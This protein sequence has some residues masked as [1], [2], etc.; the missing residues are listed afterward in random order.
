MRM[1]KST[2]DASIDISNIWISHTQYQ[3]INQI[4]I[5]FF[6]FFFLS[7]FFVYFK[8]NLDDITLNQI[9][10]IIIRKLILPRKKKVDSSFNQFAEANEYSSGLF[11]LET[12]VYRGRRPKKENGKIIRYDIS[13]S[14][15]SKNYCTGKKQ[16]PLM[17]LFFL[18]DQFMLE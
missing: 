8:S 14:G 13:K 5:V 3:I 9:I 12:K 10:I 16:R 7:F 6:L 17:F 1:L 2:L 18:K 15:L 4:V 11:L